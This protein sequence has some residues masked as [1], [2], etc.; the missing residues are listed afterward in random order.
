MSQPIPQEMPPA[1]QL[2]EMIFSPVPAQALAVA[3]KLGVAD[4]LKEQAK[5][6]DELA[7]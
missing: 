3:A 2:M 7:Q 4:L 5:S 1:A 6:A